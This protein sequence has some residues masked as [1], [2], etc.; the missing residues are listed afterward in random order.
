MANRLSRT[1]KWF[2]SDR[3]DSLVTI[4]WVVLILVCLLMSTIDFSAYMMNR[5]QMTGL[6]RDGART[7]SI[8]GGSGSSTQQ[9]TI[10][11]TYGASRANACGR[12]T[13]KPNGVATAAYNSASTAVE[14]TLM[15]T[16]NNH[17]GFLSLSVTGVKCGPSTTPNVGDRTW[18]TITW[19]YNGFPGSA[20]TFFRSSNDW[21]NSEQSLSGG[22][23]GTDGSCPKGKECSMGTSESEVRS[24]DQLVAREPQS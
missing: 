10:E 13:A 12:V 19:K 16:L 24:T 11:K 22:Y 6:A 4:P 8:Y 20:L 2:K 23:Q 7:V 17:S 3:G 9:T 14:C 18:C 5:T 1:T 21:G 15:D